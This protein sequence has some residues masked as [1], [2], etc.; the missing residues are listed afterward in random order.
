MTDSYADF[1]TDL[2]VEFV[3]HSYVESGKHEDTAGHD[4]FIWEVRDAFMCGV[5]DELC[6]EFVT[7]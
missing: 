2:C 5:L 7:D 1:V 3:N 6:V 4:L